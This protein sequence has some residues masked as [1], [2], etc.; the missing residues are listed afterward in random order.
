VNRLRSTNTKIFGA[1]G[2]SF[3]LNSPLSESDVLA[4]ENR[5]RVR[6]PAEYRSFLVH[7]GNGGAGPFYGIFPLGKMD[8]SSGQLYEDI[9]HGRVVGDLAKPFPLRKAWNDLAGAPAEEMMELDLEAYDQQLLE[10][11]QRYFD[12][13]IVNGALPICHMGC[14]MRVFLIVAGD[15]TG[16]L[17]LDDRASDNGVSPI[18]LK[19]RSRA[20]FAS[21]YLEWLEEALSHIK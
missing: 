21:W 12:P 3:V 5:H 14:A 7:V 6:L 18:F 20:T 8:G 4:F 19:C 10:F 13:S 17:W 11:E 2:H 1:D 15:E 9:Q 16:N